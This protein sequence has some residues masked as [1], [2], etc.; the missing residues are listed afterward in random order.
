MNEHDDLLN[1]LT[2]GLIGRERDAVTRAF[3][4]YATGD[5][6]SEPV[7]ISVLLTAC[8][9][10]L[11]QLPEHLQRRTDAFHQV[12]MLAKDHEKALIEKT[13]KHNSGVIA[14][15]KDENARAKQTWRD[16]ME[17]LLGFL[18]RLASINK[19]LMPVIVSARQIAQDFRAL[20]GDLK[21]HEE[22]TRKTAEGVEAIKVVHQENQIIHQDNQALIRRLGKEARANWITIGFLAGI[23]MAAV[24][25]HLPW[26]E[27]LMLLGATITLLQWLSRQSWDFVRRWIGSWK[28]SSAKAKPTG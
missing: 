24:S 5:P 16:T 11:A 17:Q 2:D 6:N 23:L 4:G 25:F 19:D 21:L 3:Y 18:D 26:R 27:G 15:F 14:E 8:M 13:T 12:V 28:S 9:R 22:S 10:K 20:Q 7:G 1:F